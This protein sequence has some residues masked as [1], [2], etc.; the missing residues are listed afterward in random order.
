[1][2]QRIQLIPS[3][4]SKSKSTKMERRAFLKGSIVLTGVLSSGSLLAA[5]APSRAWALTAQHLD[6]AQAEALLVMAKRLYPHKGLADAVYAILVKDVDDASS[7]ANTRQLVVDGIKKLNDAAQGDWTGASP[8][9]QVA[10]LKSMEND[11]FFQLVR[12]Q[13]IHSIYDNEMAYSHFGYEGEAYSKG[14]YLRRGFDDLTW[15]P[16]PSEE[17]SPAVI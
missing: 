7:D 13:C 2:R 15:L 12:G 10:I 3:P 5:L 11:A 14:G 8:E 4:K 16:E 1:M 17:A 6:T 9:E